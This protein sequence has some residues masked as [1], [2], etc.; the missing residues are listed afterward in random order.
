MARLERK[1]G[2]SID[3]KMIIEKEFE[4]DDIEVIQL[5][6][7]KTF[8]PIVQRTSEVERTEEK[9]DDIQSK[10]CSLSKILVYILVTLILVGG[11]ITVLVLLI[12]PDDNQPKH[13][14]QYIVN[15]KWQENHCYSL[16]Y[17]VITEMNSSRVHINYTSLFAIKEVSEDTIE[18]LGVLQKRFEENFEENETSEIQYFDEDNFYYIILKDGP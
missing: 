3:P 11:I 18:F 5:Q 6:S 14:E 15:R 8:K 10:K 9:D 4:Q 2:N 17:L 7:V 12:K 1:Q 13:E 16:E